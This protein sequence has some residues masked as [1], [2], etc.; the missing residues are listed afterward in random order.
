MHV[1]IFQVEKHKRHFSNTVKLTFRSQRKLKLYCVC[2]IAELYLQRIEN[3]YIKQWLDSNEIYYYKRFVDDIIILINTQK[4]KEEQLLT[5]INSIDKNPS[6]N[7][8][9]EDNNNKIN[10]LDF[11]LARNKYNIQ[12]NIHRKETSTDTVI[13]YLSNQPIEQKMAAFRYYINRILTLPLTQ[14]GRNEEWATIIN[15]AKNN[16]F[17]IGKITRLK[18]QLATR[19]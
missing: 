16:G 13:H 12:V 5:N 1:T 10:F 18:T 19:P 4:I 9:K 2:T 6:F 11:R 7:I 3:R 14:E 8:T 17:P 15:K